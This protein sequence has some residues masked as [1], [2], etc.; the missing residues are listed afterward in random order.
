MFNF[1]WIR[2]PNFRSIDLDYDEYWQERGIPL[3]GLRPREVT[4]N[5]SIP[6][7][8]KIIDIGCGN[9]SLPIILQQKGCDVTAMDVSKNVLMQLNDHGIKTINQNIENIAKDDS[10]HDVFYNWIILSEILEH[11]KNPEIIITYLKKHTENFAITIPNSALYW[12]RFGLMFKGRF[13]TQ[14]VHH[15]SEHL[16]FWSHIDFM[17]WLDAMGLI[18]KKTVSSNGPKYLKDLWPNLFGFQIVYICTIK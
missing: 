1:P 4:I 15:P 2:K 10:L 17:D 18:V 5:N 7:N 11:T 8:A 13:F 12:F 14:W 16:R 9:S 6:N 3:K